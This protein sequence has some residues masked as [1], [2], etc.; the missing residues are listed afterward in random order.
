[1]RECPDCGGRRVPCAT[2]EGLRI[3]PGE[4]RDESEAARVRITQSIWRDGLRATYER[5]RDSQR[6]P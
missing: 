3:V 2:C 6:K 5:L 1:M 4:P